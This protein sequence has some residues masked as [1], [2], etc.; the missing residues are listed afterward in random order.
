[1]ALRFL[2]IYNRRQN[3]NN[4]RPAC[5]QNNEWHEGGAE[6]SLL[7]RQSSLSTRCV[8]EE[9]LHKTLCQR[10]PHAQHLLWCHSY[11]SFT[12]PIE[13]FYALVPDLE[14][15]TTYNF[16]VRA[17]RLGCIS[18]LIN[19]SANGIATA[20]HHFRAIRCLI[21]LLVC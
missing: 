14:P 16:R 5:I 21:G 13:T 15:A 3:L 17:H 10:V 9:Y 19:F 12:T 18:C 1:M 6:F 11:H 2:R 8:P 4:G 7:P 20:P